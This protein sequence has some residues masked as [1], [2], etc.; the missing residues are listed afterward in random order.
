MNTD[1]LIRIQYSA[2]KSGIA[3]SWKKWQGEILGL[4]KMNTIAKKQEF[5]SDFTKWVDADN[6]R[7]AKYGS[8]LP[9]YKD[10]YASLKDF[11]LVNSYTNEVFTWC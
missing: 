9:S 5:E 1:P 7:K 11:T 2:K 8:I 3:N 4:D 10:L 6:S